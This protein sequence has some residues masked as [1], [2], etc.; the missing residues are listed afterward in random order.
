VYLVLKFHK[1]LEI[2]KDSK[3]LEQLALKAGIVKL[4]DNFLSIQSLGN[5]RQELMDSSCRITGK[6]M[7]AESF[8]RF[9][10]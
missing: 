6:E 10:I 5:A 7:F 8:I 3:E 2:E 4:M 1:N 9:F